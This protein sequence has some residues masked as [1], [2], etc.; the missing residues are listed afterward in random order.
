M[1]VTEADVGHVRRAFEVFNERFAALAGDALEPYHAEFFVPDS[2]VH[3]ADGFPTQGTYSGFAG[4]RR[5]F[6]DTYGPYEDVSWALES[7]A[8]HGERVVAIGL[9]GGRVPGDPTWLEIR[10]GCT[11]A[12]RDGRIARIDVFL[13]PE[14]ATAHAEQM[15]A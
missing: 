5:W 6:D 12:L 8:A 4:Y 13:T 9:S 15:S 7:V 11:Y 14:G 1:P 10:L 2:V 3:N